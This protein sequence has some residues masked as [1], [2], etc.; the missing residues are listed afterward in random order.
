MTFDHIVVTMLLVITVVLCVVKY[1]QHVIIKLVW[2][3]VVTRQL[4]DV[5]K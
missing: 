5:I 1:L 4:G 2:V 3:D